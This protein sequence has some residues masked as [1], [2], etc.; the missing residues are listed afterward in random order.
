MQLGKYIQFF[1]VEL[2]AFSVYNLVP[3]ET[4]TIAHQNIMKVLLCVLLVCFLISFCHGE[5][6]NGKID[7]VIF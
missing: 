2:N 7:A 3:T 6:K 5:M 1:I 4:Y